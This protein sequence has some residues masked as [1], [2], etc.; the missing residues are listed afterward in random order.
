MI[1]INVSSDPM[2]TVDITTADTL[3][4]QFSYSVKW[5]E[6]TITYD[7]RMD[8]YARYSF[9]PQ[10]LEVRGHTARA[11]RTARSPTART[12]MQPQ[13]RGSSQHQ[14]ATAMQPASLGSSPENPRHAL[15]AVDGRGQ[16]VLFLQRHACTRTFKRCLVPGLLRNNAC[17][18]SQAKP[19]GL[20]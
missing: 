12:C 8:R 4:V 19:D 3:T 11:A 17:P 20:W 1:E 10:H 6:T 2:R 9:L 7:H 16:L 5:K 13:A 18:G 15:V 14:T